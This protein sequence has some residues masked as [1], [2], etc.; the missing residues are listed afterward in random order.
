MK[1]NANFKAVNNYCTKYKLT[2]NSDLSYWLKF[3]FPKEMKMIEIDDFTSKII[4]KKIEKPVKLNTNHLTLNTRLRF[5]KYKDYTIEKIIQMNIG[6]VK[7]L[8]GIWEGIVT[9]EV[10]Y[11]V[12]KIEKNFR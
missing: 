11:A 2:P 9:D 6:Y 5:G 1:I 12:N 10:S 3:G 4:S 8:T 7:W